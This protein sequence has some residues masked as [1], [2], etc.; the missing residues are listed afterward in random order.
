MQDEELRL[1]QEQ[2]TSIRKEIE[3]V[4]RQ[5]AIAMEIAAQIVA[6]AEA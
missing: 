2:A 6:A 4:Q 3:E 1:L 5:V